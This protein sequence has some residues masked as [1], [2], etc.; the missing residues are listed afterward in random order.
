[1][2]AECVERVDDHDEVL[3][4]VTRADAIRHHWLHRI[5]TITC[6]DPQGR[7]LV[8]RRPA[9][10]SRFP[11]HYNWMLGGAVEVSESYEQAAARE[12]KE[13]LGVEAAPRFIFKYRCEGAISP[14]WLALHEA[15]V[16]T[17]LTP[18]PTEIAWHAWLT[19][20][21]LTHLVQHENFVPDAR[22]A[23]RRYRESGAGA[24]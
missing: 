5:A 9:T 10:A 17:P 7:Y 1:M 18:D 22:E 4:V 12:L 8:H 21:E 15:V 20:A 6:R 13:E 16:T 24:G 3:S 14:Y 2:S 23:F 19:P 11:G